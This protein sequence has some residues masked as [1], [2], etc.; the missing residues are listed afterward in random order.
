VVVTGTVV[1]VTASALG[2]SVTFHRSTVFADLPRIVRVTTHDFEF[3]EVFGLILVLRWILPSVQL[4]TVLKP[5]TFG[6]TDHVHVLA[7][8][9]IAVNVTVP[10]LVASLL[11]CV[12]VAAFAN[13][14]E[15]RSVTIKM[16]PAPALSVLR[17]SISTAP[18]V[19]V[20]T[21]W[22]VGLPSAESS[23]CRPSA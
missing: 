23:T 8:E 7:F 17:R 13:P 21:R 9:T 5:V 12:F 22:I 15:T 11:V 19:V 1:V 18:A 3:F 16:N 6:V 10:P 14:A 2:A 4:A 20:H